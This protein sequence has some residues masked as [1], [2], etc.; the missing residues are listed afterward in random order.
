MISFAA[1]TILF[2]VSLHGMSAIPLFL[3]YGRYASAGDTP[4]TEVMSSRQ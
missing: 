3:L 4:T 2:S 1:L